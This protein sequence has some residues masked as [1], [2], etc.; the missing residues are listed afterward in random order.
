MKHK[1]FLIFLLC[2]S[3]TGWS[4]SIT[5]TFAGKDLQSKPVKLN[6]IVVANLT[7]NWEE[8]IYNPEDTILVMGSTGVNDF[9]NRYEFKLSQNYP[10]PFVGATDFSLQKPVAGKVLLSVFGLTGRKITMYQ[11]NLPAGTHVFRVILKTPQS[12]V[13]TARCGSHVASIKM[14]NSG[15]AGENVIRYAGED[16]NNRLNMLLKGGAVTP[17]NIGDEMKYVGY[18]SINGIETESEP[19]QKH[20]LTSEEIMLVFGTAGVD[21]GAPCPAAATVTDYDGNIYNT[22]QIGQQCWMKENL[23]TSRYADGTI[24]EL[25]SL[26]S[27]TTA[28]R[29]YPGGNANNVPSYGYLYNHKAVMRDEPSCNG[30]RCGLQGIC[31]EGW[32]VPSEAE[33]RLLAVYVGNQNEYLCNTNRGHIAKALASERWGGNLSEDGCAVNQ[34]TDKNN[35]TG[36]SA[37]PAGC[38]LAD[39]GEFGKTAF[40]WS[41]TD[42]STEEAMSMKLG[43]KSVGANKSEQVKTYAFSVRCL[44]DGTFLLPAAV[45]TDNVSDIKCNSAVVTGDVTSDGGNQVTASGVCWSTKPYPTIADSHTNEGAGLGSFQSKISFPA[46]GVEQ[47]YYVCAYAENSAG[48]TYGNEK[49]FSSLPVA[50]PMKIT[51]PTP[52]SVVCEYEINEMDELIEHGV[53]WSTNENPTVEDNHTVGGIS[54]GK[55]TCILLGLQKDT[56][57]YVRVYVIT[58]NG[59]TYGSEIIDFVV[60]RPCPGAP[61]ITD[62]D[63]N[64]YNT[65]KIGNQCWMKENLKTTKYADGTS[66]SQ[67]STTSDAV[68]YWY[69]P[70]NDSVYKEGYGLLYNWRAVMY[71][72]T[73]SN[74]NPSGVQGVCPTGWHVPS[75]A[76]WTQLTDYVSSQRV[77]QCNSSNSNIAKSLASI[78]GWTTST[79]TC[80]V[81]ND[82]TRNNAT[83]FGALPAGRYYGSYTSFG[84]YA[85]FW[86]ASEN[87]QY[88]RT[89]CSRRLHYDNAFVHGPNEYGFPYKSAGLSVRCLRDASEPIITLPKVNTASVTGIPFTTATSGGEIYSFGGA[90]ITARGVCWST[91]HNPTIS[92][93]KTTDGTGMGSFVSHL[94]G[95]TIGTTYYVRA[96]ATNSMGASYGEERSFTTLME[97]TVTTNEVI[98]IRNTTATCGGNVNVAEGATVT[99]RGVCWS[100]TPNPTIR[101][102]KTTDGAGIGSY[103]SSMTGLTP[104]TTYYVRA[105]VTYSVGTSYGEE[106]SFVTLLYLSCPGAATVTDCENNIYNTIQIGTQCWMAENLRTEHYADGTKIDWYY[107]YNSSSNK[108]TYGLLYNW[109]AVMHNSSSSNTNP[110][111]VQG[112]CPTGWHVP[113]DVEWTQ[114][115]DYVSGQSD[116][117][118][119]SNTSSI[120]KALASTTGWKTNSSLCTVGNDQESNNITGFSAVPA[121]LYHGSYSNFGY[122][123]DFWSATEASSNYAYYRRLSSDYAGVRRGNLN[124][125]YG[126]SVRCLR[127]N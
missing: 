53:C 98:N 11:G 112:I 70:N 107:P 80:A 7:K 106:R 104:G 110:S 97:P 37:L 35:T 49:S 121:G 67:G 77:C 2:G 15:H 118:C 50:K 63:N 108:D 61:T 119:G 74:A 47:Q 48:I 28:Y 88:G 94:S 24:I 43:S 116:Y 58:S 124:K 68:A 100:T 22:V 19:I 127:D 81:G 60:P 44:K 79:N 36:F 71:N 42:I 114:L 32:H 76:E 62:V 117:V 25:G 13:L 5:L 85:D 102:S 92:D 66:I 56:V 113:S 18:A 17:F 95:L 46:S 40:F 122:S 93:S 120:A 38:H 89:A 34:N 75:D 83:G 41:A 126:F 55:D 30:D 87:S 84:S 64:T 3:L 39:A 27:S 109:M 16:K 6:K 4:Q 57:T 72:S 59:V 21:D 12:Y 52:D 96:Y 82:Q 54:S 14:I 8:T 26:V 29:Y 105:Y 91:S 73:S 90:P 115:T 86:N 111:G 125:N 1:L 20:Q 45:S 23:R 65:V 123:V 31:P 99:A 69:Y 10:K 51:I 101:D 103:T 9:E 33:W 78:T